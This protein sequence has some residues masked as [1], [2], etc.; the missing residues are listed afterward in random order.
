MYFILFFFFKDLAGGWFFIIIEIFLFLD[1]ARTTLS[2]SSPAARVTGQS[3]GQVT[4]GRNEVTS[5]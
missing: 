2:P 4:V 3:L 1:C 5:Q